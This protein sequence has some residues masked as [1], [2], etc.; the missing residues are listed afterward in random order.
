[1][2]LLLSSILGRFWSFFLKMSIFEFKNAVFDKNHNK[3]SEFENAGSEFSQNVGLVH[4]KRRRHSVQYAQNLGKQ[5][6]LYEPDMTVFEPLATIKSDLHVD[7]NKFSGSQLSMNTFREGVSGNFP[8]SGSPYSGTNQGTP[9]LWVTVDYMRFVQT[10]TICLIR[11][12]NLNVSLSSPYHS[13]T[14]VILT[15][16]VGIENESEENKIIGINQQN[17]KTNSVNFNAILRIDNIPEKLSQKSLRFTVF[18]LDTRKYSS[19]KNLRPT[20]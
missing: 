12:E 8:L 14:L 1:M 17:F 19:F 4:Q 15:Q 11:A 10:I 5:G 3:I 20:T 16:L 7:E 2:T 13:S 18:Q 6:S 9:R